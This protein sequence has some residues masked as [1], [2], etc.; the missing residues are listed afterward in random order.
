MKMV[1]IEPYNIRSVIKYDGTLEQLQDLV[2]GYVEAI[3]QSDGTVLLVNEEG[4]LQN[5]PINI[6]DLC[7]NILIL[8]VKGDDFTGLT[9]KDIKKYMEV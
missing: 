8:R 5:L 7:G 9:D 3:Y 2:G 1:L 4:K 6:G